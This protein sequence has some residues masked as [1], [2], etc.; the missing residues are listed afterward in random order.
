M[1]HNPDVHSLKCPKCD[2]GMEEVTYDDITID[3]CTG[4]QGLWFDAGELQQLK[5]RPGAEAVDTGNPA[6]GRKY[7]IRDNISCPRCG[8]AMEKSSDW[9]QVHIWYEVCREHGLFMDAGEF[10]DFKFDTLLDWFRGLRK[11]KRGH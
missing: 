11:G 4:C 9:K 1:E 5:D 3:R 8:R 2:H 10:T 7:D 6:K